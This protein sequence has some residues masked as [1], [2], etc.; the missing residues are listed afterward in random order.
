MRNGIAA[1]WLAGMAIM[2]WRQVHQSHRM[3]VPGALLGVT[4]LFAAGGVV[5]EVFPASARLVT[6]GL[7]GLD[8]AA[9]LGALPAGLGGQISQ[10]EQATAAAE[11]NRAENVGSQAAQHAA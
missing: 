3:P 7:F 10:Q 5:S 6:L 2:V 1:A 8:V 9:L 11:Y 4:A